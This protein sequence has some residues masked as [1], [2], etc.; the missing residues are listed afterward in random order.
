MKINSD[1]YKVPPGKKVKLDEWPT[2]EKPFCN[3]R[4]K[5]E[6]LLSSHVDKLSALQRLHYAA[7]PYA[8]PI[9]FQGMD[10]RVKFQATRG[11]VIR[12]VIDTNV[13]V[14]ALIAPAGNEALIVLAVSQAG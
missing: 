14:S 3:S 5:Y 9:I 12:A 10:G 8:L 1:D 11:E 6:Q 4:K 13:V 7:G 2:I